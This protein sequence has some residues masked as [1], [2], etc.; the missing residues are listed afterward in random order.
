MTSDCRACG[1]RCARRWSGHRDRSCRPGRSPSPSRWSCRCRNRR[2]FRPRSCAARR[3]VAW[4]LPCALRMNRM[5]PPVRHVRLSSHARA[6]LKPQAHSRPCAMD[7]NA[8]RRKAFGDS[9]RT[10]SRPGPACLSLASACRSKP[11]RSAYERVMRA[12]DHATRSRRRSVS[13]GSR[14]ANPADRPAAPHTIELKAL[15]STQRRSRHGFA[16]R[17]QGHRN[18]NPTRR[19]QEAP[20]QKAQKEVGT[21]RLQVDR[22]TKAFYMTRGGRRSRGTG[23]QEGPSRRAGV[24][25]QFRRRREQD[26]RAAERPEAARAGAAGRRIARAQSSSISSSS[27][28]TVGFLLAVGRCRRRRPRPRFVDSAARSQARHDRHRRWPRLERAPRPRGAAFGR[29]K[30]ASHVGQTIGVLCRS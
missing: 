25:L 18:P 3:N 20:N 10:T 9:P 22:Q 27:D 1:G 8:I 5:V 21:Y 15:E 17:D 30:T 26:H 6:R 14:C 7:S 29:T 12:N 2:R 23:H 16:T 19:V 24:D 4:P 13:G 28:A 11:Q